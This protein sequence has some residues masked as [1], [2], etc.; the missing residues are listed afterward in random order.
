MS[1]TPALGA[2]LLGTATSAGRAS[3]VTAATLLTQQI[4]GYA[5]QT[6]VEAQFCWIYLKVSP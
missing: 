6:G 5:A 2:S 1:G 3:L 4:V